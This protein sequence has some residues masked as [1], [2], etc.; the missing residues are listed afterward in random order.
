MNPEKWLNARPH[1]GADSL[2]PACSA[3]PGLRLRR[4]PIVAFPSNNSLP[5]GRM[6]HSPL[7]CFQPEGP[8]RQKFGFQ[9]LGVHIYFFSFDG[10]KGVNRV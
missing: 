2:A 1:V 9:H 5:Q 6:N 7:A 10:L 4:I 8:F 3:L